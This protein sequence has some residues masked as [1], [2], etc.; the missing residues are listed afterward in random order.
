MAIPR[1][2]RRGKVLKSCWHPQ[3][4]RLKGAVFR[5]EKARR[6]ESVHVPGVTSALSLWDP[7]DPADSLISPPRWWPNIVRWSINIR[8]K[9]DYQNARWYLYVDS[10]MVATVLQQYKSKTLFD[11]SC[12][13][14]CT[15]AVAFCLRPGPW[16]FGRTGSGDHGL[17][18]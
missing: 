1:P 2:S 8:E 13:S 7:A 11:L 16:I 15:V 3:L 17:G 6:Y 14:S 9:G 4:C 12:L 5:G 10:N 18:G